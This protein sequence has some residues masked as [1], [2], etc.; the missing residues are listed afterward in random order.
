MCNP[1]IFSQASEQ[2]QA[3]HFLK[4]KLEAMSAF[5]NDIAEQANSNRSYAD[6]LNILASQQTR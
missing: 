1:T 4:R 6:E 2:E 3:V 5:A